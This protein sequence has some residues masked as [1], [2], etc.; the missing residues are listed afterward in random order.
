MYIIVNVGMLLAEVSGTEH[1][2]LFFPH[3][4][5]SDIQPAPTCLY[6]PAGV[7]ILET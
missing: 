4:V 3:Y 2:S 7:F 6:R 1:L 5:S